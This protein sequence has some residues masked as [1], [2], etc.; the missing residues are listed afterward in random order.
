MK[1]AVILVALFALLVSCRSGEEQIRDVVKNYL[2]AEMVHA[3]PQRAYIYLASADKEHT[4]VEVY[5]KE[6]AE[7][8]A[9]PDAAFTIDTVEMTADRANVTVTLSNDGVEGSVYA[10]AVQVV[11]EA[12][13]TD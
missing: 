11:P 8:V 13:R 12:V 2:E 4:T 1:R 9:L 10:D 6:R 3:A 7:L 5:A